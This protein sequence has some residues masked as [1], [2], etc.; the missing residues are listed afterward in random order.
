MLSAEI[1]YFFINELL[2]YLMSNE[3]E[4][5]TQRLDSSC[6]TIDL[7]PWQDPERHS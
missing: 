7:T 2:S 1:Q 6:Q 3:T 5:S 4:A